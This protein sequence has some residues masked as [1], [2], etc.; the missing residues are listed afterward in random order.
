M[1]KNF[2]CD[3][4]GKPMSV[5][6]DFY[7]YVIPVD[8]HIHIEARIEFRNKMTQVD[9]DLCADCKDKLLVK[10]GKNIME[11]YGAKSKEAT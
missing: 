3:N 7:Q 1:G 8:M 4:C 10:L 9:S 5:G 11:T 2:F 6:G